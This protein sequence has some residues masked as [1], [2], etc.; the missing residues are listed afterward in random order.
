MDANLVE[1]LQMSLS[2]FCDPWC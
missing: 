1:T 2:P